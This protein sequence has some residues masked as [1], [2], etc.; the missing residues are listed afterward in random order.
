MF[1]FFI[2]FFCL[3]YLGGFFQKIRSVLKY[4]VVIFLFLPISHFL[5]ERYGMATIF[6]GLF[7]G[8]NKWALPGLIALNMIYA[9]TYNASTSFVLCLFYILLLL[10]P[11]YKFFKQTVILLLICFCIFFVSLLSDLS[12]IANHFSFYNEIA[13]RNVMASNWI[14]GLDPNN[15]WRLVLWKQFLV[16]LFPDNLFGVGLGTPAVSYFPVADFSKL[17]TLPYVLGAHNSFI[18][19]FSRL[20]IMYL[21]LIIP[22]YSIV[23]KEYFLQK[24][25]YKKTN[26][27]FIFYSF[28]AISVISLFN[29]TLE[30]PIFASGYWLVLGFLARCIFNRQL[31]EK[32]KGADFIY[33]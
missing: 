3:K 25:Y 1:A 33:S 18:Y 12:L 24:W 7:K 6:P 15:T 32:G 29:P 13:I 31:L 21:L 14:L 2:G 10:S 27:I 11:G 26:E 20:G 4:Y 30:S 23:F 5:Y 17:D 19:L 28:F 22:V 16:D 9:V 8:R